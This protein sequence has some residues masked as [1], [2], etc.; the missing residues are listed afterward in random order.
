MLKFIQARWSECGLSA[1]LL[2]TH[3]QQ[4]DD[5]RY[6]ILR[7]AVPNMN[8]EGMFY[9]NDALKVHQRSRPTLSLLT[10]GTG[11]GL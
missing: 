10:S 4:V 5:V 7:G 11:P 8:V 1:R 9:V 2:H 3:A 6:R